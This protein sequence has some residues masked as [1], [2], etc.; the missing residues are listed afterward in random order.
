MTTQDVDIDATRI[1]LS[2]LRSQFDNI[3]R[4]GGIFTDLKKIY[5]EIKELECHLKALEWESDN[6]IRNYSIYF[7]SF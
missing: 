5:M 4:D 6:R 3:M 7:K 1:R 2:E